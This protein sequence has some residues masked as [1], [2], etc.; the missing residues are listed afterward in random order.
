MVSI[1]LKYVDLTQRLS[2]FVQL[3]D[4]LWLS[5][6]LME[7]GKIFSRISDMSL[8]SS[9]PNVIS[10]SS[11]IICSDTVFRL[12]VSD[13]LDKM[14]L[15]TASQQFDCSVENVIPFGTNF[16]HPILKCIP[17]ELLFTSQSRWVKSE[18][19]MPIHIWIFSTESNTSFKQSSVHSKWSLIPNVWNSTHF[20]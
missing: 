12:I 4:F 10:L 16:H 15:K 3:W 2:Y 6:S 7:P 1:N 17:L 13:K 11:S 18:T 20:F 5:I 14:F 9:S 8:W 19:G